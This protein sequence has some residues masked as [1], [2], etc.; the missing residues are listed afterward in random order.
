MIHA[1][2]KKK[3]KADLALSVLKAL[4][5]FLTLLLLRPAVPIHDPGPAGRPARDGLGRLHRHG[6][7]GQ[8]AVRRRR[9]H[10]RVQDRVPRRA[11]RRVEQRGLP[12][13][14]LQLPGNLASTIV[15]W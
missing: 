8:A 11:G 15:G 5:I 3:H 2:V 6:G 14:G 7:V 1:S 10:P 4:S 9:P 12:C 13:Q